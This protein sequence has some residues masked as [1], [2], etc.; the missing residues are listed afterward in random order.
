[1][2]NNLVYGQ[3]FGEINSENAT[4]TVSVLSPF[5]FM[6]LMEHERIPQ[7]SIILLRDPYN[8]TTLPVPRPCVVWTLL[9]D[10]S[11][12]HAAKYTTETQYLKE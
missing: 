6:S 7:S 10:R 5:S 4:F 11:V 8:V 1:M 3:F 9:L 12:S 2:K